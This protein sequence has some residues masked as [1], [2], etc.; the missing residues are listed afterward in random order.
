MPNLSQPVREVS[1]R[2]FGGLVTYVDPRDLPGGAS[3][4]CTDVSFLVEGVGIRPGLTSLASN[5]DGPYTYFLYYSVGG[6][7][8]S[9]I[10]FHTHLTSSPGGYTYYAAPGATALGLLMPNGYVML[11]MS[12]P[13]TPW[14]GSGDPLRVTPGGIFRQMGSSAPGVAPTITESTG[15]WRPTTISQPSPAKTCYSIIY[16][17]PLDDTNA[18]PP[19]NVLTFLGDVNDVTFNYGVYPGDYVYAAGFTDVAGV[20]H[21]DGTY[22]VIGIGN[23]TGRYGYQ[24]YI[25]VRSPISCGTFAGPFT[26]ATVQKTRALVNVVPPLPAEGLVD[27]PSVTIGGTATGASGTNQYIWNQA[28]NVI[29]TPTLYE[30]QVI[31]TQNSGNFAA[32]EFYPVGSANPQWQADNSYNT[33]DTIIDSYGHCW[34]AAVSGLSAGGIPSFPANPA[35]GATITD[36][37]ITW[38]FQYGMQLTV[39][40]FNTTNSNGIFNVQNAAVTSV[41]NNVMVTNV[42]VPASTININ[43]AG[44]AIC[45]GGALLVIDPGQKTVG[46]GQPGVN[47][48]YAPV[49]PPQASATISVETPD[50]APGQRYCIV[51]FQMEDGSI[52]PASPPVSFYTTGTTNQLTI[53]AAGRGGTAL[54]L[55][56]QGTIARIVAFT[57]AGAGFGGPYFYIPS[58]VYLPPTAA[59]L[60]QP[61]T[62]SATV[63]YDNTTT[64]SQINFTLTDAVLLNSVNITEEGNNRQQTRGIRPFAKALL[65]SGRA[66][67]IGEQAAVTTL[68][69]TDFS[70]GTLGETNVI[71]GWTFRPGN[72]EGTGAFSIQ[73]NVS[74]MYLEMANTSGAALNPTANSLANAVCLTQSVSL[75][76]ENTPVL[77]PLTAYNVRVLCAASNPADGSS[78]RIEIDN[79]NGTVVRNFVIPASSMGSNIIAPTEFDGVILLESDWGTGAEAPALL[80]L[81]PLNQPSGSAFYVYRVDIYPATQP[82]NQSQVAVSYA[83]DPAGVDTVTG[84]VDISDFTQDPITN[85]Y[86]FLASVYV[87]T[88]TRTFHVVTTSD[89]EPAFWEVREVANRAG[90]SGPLAQDAAEEFAVTADV[91]GVYVFDGGAHLRISQEIQQIWNLVVHPELTWVKVDLPNQRILV[92]VCLPTPN[93]WLPNDPSDTPTSPNVILSCQFFGIDSGRELG[94]EAPVTVSMFTGALLFREMRRKWS[95]WRIPAHYADSGP[96]GVSQIVLGHDVPN[97]AYT[98][99]YLDPTVYTDMGAAIQQS[100]T[101]YAI[102]DS[103]DTQQLQLG[104][105]YHQYSYGLVLAEGAG[106]MTV[107]GTPENLR[108]TLPAFTQPPFTLSDPALDDVNLP[109]NITGNRLFLTVAASGTGSW[110]NLRRIVLGVQEARRVTVRGQ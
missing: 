54:P 50:L 46:T 93:T 85:I 14:T 68:V 2:R 78:L 20:P 34:S 38:Q 33:G 87:T 65:D 32:I 81:F 109:L 74:R 12:Q 39:T 88:A 51:L 24:K 56:P 3:P 94:G 45:G 23:Y 35:V 95:I 62:I 41:N 13:G 105:H 40:V 86:R 90:C 15:V 64:G 8:Q 84:V 96:N 70:G 9:I 102:P 37:Q 28:W 60:G 89:A 43:E 83:G 30:L 55:G 98:L 27:S 92:G 63:V 67:Y 73:S 103:R 16:G 49:A 58:P 104:S 17:V 108:N 57:A 29:A 36:N 48:I 106:Q 42:A 66:F 53:S 11:G 18:P 52:T 59:S 26:G 7:A 1:L 44:Y 110:F 75:T 61:K 4:M 69:N 76:A 5:T 97:G 101:T 21:L 71:P 91:N 80:G 22:Q 99:A 79:V 82:A 107:L 19:S 31:A 10:Q 100:Y 25:Q 72:G 47:P 6:T 77:V